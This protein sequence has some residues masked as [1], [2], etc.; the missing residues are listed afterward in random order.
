MVAKTQ[1]WKN[2]R[3]A[4]II[5]NIIH[6]LV[7]LAPIITIFIAGLCDGEL[8]IKSKFCLGICT[9]AAIILLVF[10]V[11]KKIK[12]RTIF[13]L[14]MLG[15]CICVNNIFAFV[16][17]FLSCSSVDEFIILP[18]NKAMKTKFNKIDAARENA[19]YI[20]ELEK[21]KE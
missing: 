17:V 19:S 9:V 2:F 12:F 18:I 8:G 5:T 15:L 7:S 10:E 11:A 21:E 3:K 1:R 20:D 14:I 4:V 6:V 16:I 13:W